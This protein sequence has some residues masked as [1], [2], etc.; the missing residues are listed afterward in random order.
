MTL[1]VYVLAAIGLLAVTGTVGTLAYLAATWVFDRR[2]S[3]RPTWTRDDAR[4]ARTLGITDP[5]RVR[6]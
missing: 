6:C 4:E 3:R 1:A 5:R 2:D